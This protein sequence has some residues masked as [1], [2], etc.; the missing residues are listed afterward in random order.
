[1]SQ[2]SGQIVSHFCTNLKANQ[3]KADA[4]IIFQLKATQI[5]GH[6]FESV[7]KQFK[8]LNADLRSNQY[9]YI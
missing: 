9:K 3:F 8:Y 5:L 6:L 7:S 4:M 2:I 1:M